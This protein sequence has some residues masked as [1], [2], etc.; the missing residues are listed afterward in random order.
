MLIAVMIMMV[1]TPFSFR[2]GIYGKSQLTVNRKR[3]QDLRYKGL[4]RLMYISSRRQ[5]LSN[6]KFH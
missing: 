3:V 5:N 6:F 2:I 1:M 4:Y